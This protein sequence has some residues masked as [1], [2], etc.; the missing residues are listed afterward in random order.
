MP[1]TIV[2]DHPGCKGKY[3][4]VKKSSPQGKMFGCHPTRE[5]AGRQ[6]G[7]IESSEQSVSIETVSLTK[8]TLA[9]ETHGGQ[10]PD[11]WRG[12]IAGLDRPTGDERYLATPE[13]GVRTREFP[14]TL[15]LQHVGD[16]TDI[17]IG[18]VERVWVE[19]GLLHGEGKFDLEGE[20]GR[21][22]ARRLR[23][24]IANTVSIH[25]DQVKAEY[26]VFNDKGER[27][28][29][30]DLEGLEELPD[31]WAVNTIF[32]DWRLAGLAVV[33]IPAYTEARIEPVYGY[34]RTEAGD[35]QVDAIVASVGGQLFTP[36]FFEDPKLRRPTRLT[37]TDDGRVFGHVALWD[38]CYQYSGLNAGATCTKPPRSATGYANFTSHKARLADGRT[39]AVGVVTYGEGHV[40]KGS[41]R[42]SIAHLNNVSQRAA[43]VVA[44]EDRFGIWLSGEILDEVRDHGHDLLSAP[45]SGHWEPDA[46]AAGNLEM[47]GAHLVNTPGFKPAP[48]VASFKDGVTLDGLTLTQQFRSET[49][50]LS[51]W[52]TETVQLAVAEA[53]A[54]KDAEA[55]RRVTLKARLTDVLRSS[56]K[57][58]AEVEGPA[59]NVEG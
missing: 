53:L 31:G 50:D 13:G 36:E 17:P 20:E 2:T 59:A 57:T 47:I 15:T 5:A 55:R 21:E 44:G 19:N 58:G 25:P 51:D 54:A 24:G 4:V 45:L 16:G 38:G 42:H 8:A 11:G 35:G 32:S 3:A 34:E 14:L 39:I 49:D 29:E 46:Q 1:Y 33:S 48:L 18:N 41:L 30:E 43:K 10:L 12:V 56:E 40:S 9:D 28:S 37:V 27:V 7:A 6:I 52:I 23:D 22:T 26:G